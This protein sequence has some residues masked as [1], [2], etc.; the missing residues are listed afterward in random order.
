M[1][2]KE[3]PAQGERWISIKEQYPAGGL[4]LAFVPP[5]IMGL[6][7]LHKGKIWAPD[8]EEDREFV[9]VTHWRPL[10][11]PPVE[12]P[13]GRTICDGHSGR[14]SAPEE[15]APSQIVGYPECGAIYS[16]ME[17]GG[18]TDWGCSNSFHSRGRTE[19]SAGG[20]AVAFIN[21]LKS[22]GIDED[23][24]KAALNRLHQ[25][26]IVKI[27]ADWNVEASRANWIESINHE[28]AS[29]RA[30]A[31][32]VEREKEAEI[33]KLKLALERCIE[34]RGER[35]KVFMVATLA[36]GDDA[37]KKEKQDG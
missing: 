4:F 7:F 3:A 35:D 26:G 31:N 24:A 21:T 23:H 36:L 13:A 29:L 9:N 1:S 11:D 32:R 25:E 15:S 19:T 16:M 30:W 10:P 37:G 6:A 12:I 5:N 27:D 33:A 28:L 2:E 14:T 20:S 34:V 18:T 22:V 17:I 8:A